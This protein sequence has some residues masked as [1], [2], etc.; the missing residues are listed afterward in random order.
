MSYSFGLW[1]IPLSR[2]GFD[3]S[4]VTYLATRLEVVVQCVDYDGAVSWFVQT[5]ATCL[6]AMCKDLRSVCSL[7]TAC[8]DRQVGLSSTLVRHVRNMRHRCAATVYGNPHASGLVRI[9]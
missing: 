7:G 3:G 2:P 1:S 8:S 6:V 4:S 9:G 5:K